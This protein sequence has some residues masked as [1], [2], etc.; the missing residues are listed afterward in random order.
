MSEPAAH[1]VVTL[2]LS[3]AAIG[4]VFSFAFLILGAKRVDESV[5][6]STKGYAVFVFPGIAALWP[7][8][9]VKRLGAKGSRS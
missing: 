3:Y 1:I 2:F 7:L 5:T 6:G 8:M 9:A 4:V